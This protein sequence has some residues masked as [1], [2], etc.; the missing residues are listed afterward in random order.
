ML[1]RTL[2]KAAPAL[3]VA[4]RLARAQT[5]GVM[6]SYFDGYSYLYNPGTIDGFPS[7]SPYGFFAYAYRN[8]NQANAPNVSTSQL[9]PGY[10]A[11]SSYIYTNGLLQVQDDPQA[12]NGIGH[13]QWFDW[14]LPQELKLAHRGGQFRPLAEDLPGPRR[15]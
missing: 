10:Y 2:L 15:R 7:D 14:P 4:P 12:F 8:Q 13:F 6:A 9:A 11:V 5:A 3:L 1:R